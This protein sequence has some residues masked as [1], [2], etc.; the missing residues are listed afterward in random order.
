MSTK[1]RT[2]L[3]YLGTCDGDMEKGN[4]RADVNVSVRRPGDDA[5]HALRDQER[6]L[7]PLHRPGDRVRGAAPDRHSRG[8]R[9]DRPGDP[10]VRSRARA[11]PARCARRRRRT[12]TATSPTRTSC[13][14]SSTQAYVD[15]LAQHLPELPD[16]KK[17]RFI[18][19]YGL[20]PYDAGVLVGE[21]ASA[22]Y[23]EAVGEGPRRQ[24]RRELGHQRAV[25]APQ[26]GRA[27]ASR[28]SPVSA[29]AARRPSST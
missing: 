18:A 26:Q 21:R 19:D 25:R 8:R 16:A 13:R 17:A 4:L 1:L 14:S 22:D 3:R 2:I 29:G 27:G 5:R 23:F 20:S 24:G 6:Q 28:T 10:P 9:R 12:T 7:D 15:D 11:R